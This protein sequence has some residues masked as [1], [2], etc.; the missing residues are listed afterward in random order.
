[1]NLKPIT[2]K[3]A[4]DYVKNLH[5]HHI[6]PQGHKLSIGLESDEKL[7]GIVMVGRPV[8]RVLDDGYTAE[9]TRCCTD[10]SQNA[11]SMLYGAARRAAKAM[12]YR[13]IITYVLD[14]EPGTS[15]KAAGWECH[16]SA[17]GGSWDVPSRRRVDKAPTQKKI[18]WECS[19]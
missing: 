2:F 3:V 7:I 19:L 4:C 13:K 10:G 9:V 11:C 17:G 1:M 15:I 6:P 5:R 16:G 12:G 14:T 8:S 18:R